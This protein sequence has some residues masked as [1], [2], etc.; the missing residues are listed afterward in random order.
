MDL[1]IAI[2]PVMTDADH[3]PVARTFGLAPGTLE[4]GPYAKMRTIINLDTMF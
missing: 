3:I 1:K 2:A 4:G